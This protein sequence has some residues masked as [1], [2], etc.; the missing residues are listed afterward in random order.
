MLINGFLF[1]LWGLNFF[2]IAA[3]SDILMS[4]AQMAI[5]VL[6]ISIILGINS[7][8]SHRYFRV[9]IDKIHSSKSIKSLFLKDVI[10]IFIIFT[11]L[12]IA[13]LWIPIALSLNAFDLRDLL[14]TK[15]IPSIWLA[16]SMAVLSIFVTIYIHL[17]TS[18]HNTVRFVKLKARLRKPVVVG[19]TALVFAFACVGIYALAA[20][21]DWEVFGHSGHCDE[22]FT[23]I[24]LGAESIVARCGDAD[25]PIYQ[26]D[27]FYVIPR[28]A[29]YLVK[30]G[31]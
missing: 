21:P 1:S 24:W 6:F 26:S 3:P 16:I 28:R 23:A 7:F 14:D 11:L 22:K 4:G 9:V 2:Q 19:L 13:A 20:K 18:Y 31:E 29:I 27:S 15:S 25:E 10:P 8:I 30:I 12:T 5:Y 17:A